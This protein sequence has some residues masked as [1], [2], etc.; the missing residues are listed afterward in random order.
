MVCRI[1]GS[2][3]LIVLGF[4]SLQA[5]SKEPDP[6]EWAAQIPPAGV[7]WQPD[8]PYLAPERPERM[9]L[10][11]P[12]EQPV[13]KR[14]PAMVI[15]HGGGWGGVRMR[16]REWNLGCTLAQA[17]YV[18]INLEY[19]R[20]PSRR[21]P[22]NVLDCK[23]GVR[24]LRKHADQY[25]IDPN[26]IGVIGSSAGGHLA[27]MVAYT[28]GIAEL[29]PTTPYPG[30]PDGVAACVDLYGITDLAN[31]QEVTDDG[32]P[33]GVRLTRAGLFQ[34]SMAKDPERWRLAS[35]ISHVRASSPPT[36]IIHGQAD[37]LVDRDQSTSLAAALAKVGAIHELVLIPKAPHA[38]SLDDPKLAIRPWPLVLKFLGQH[39]GS[40]TAATT[41]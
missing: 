33:T 14:R 13:G 9:D 31:R 35:P 12:A 2:I 7:T 3:L 19:E 32:T 30:I 21:W 6:A 17:G 24:F 40:R 20:S 8:L 18:C 1:T 23:N 26:R 29:S 25:H 36:L 5:A 27:L 28:T 37:A 11:L 39:L 38:F 34:D 41:P 4:G 22:N 16:H 15:I 10:F